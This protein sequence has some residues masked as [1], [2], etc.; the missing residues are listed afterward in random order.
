MIG[1]N[2]RIAAGLAALALLGAVPFLASFSLEFSGA[3]AVAVLY[4]FAVLSVVILTGYVG[5]FSLCQATFMGISAFGTAALVNHGWAYLPAAGV[6]VTLSFL[7]GVLVALPAL[8][9]SGILLAVV[10]AG[11]AL[12][13]D[14][15]FFQDNAFSWFNGGVSGWGISG[16]TIFGQQLDGLSPEHLRTLFLISLGIFAVVAVLVV[17][18][19]DSGSGRR[20][21][22]IRDSEV[23]AATMGV[24]LTRYKLL[25][26]GLSAAVA[27]IGGAI[28]P[29]VQGSVTQSPFNFFYSLQ[30]AAIAVLMGIRFIP[31]ATLGGIFIAFTPPLLPRLQD[32]ASNVLHQPIEI[33]G[34]WF[35]LVLGTLLVVQI[36]LYPDGVWGDAAHRVMALINPPQTRRGAK[37]VAA[38]RR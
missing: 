32:L 23:A 6:G 14:Y 38:A 13:F 26:F 27:G 35:Q 34:L 15:F 4:G 9:L 11:V 33:K 20:F 12:S 5:Q 21:R 10:T 19:H 2:G 3:A 36:I 24:D 18:I 30:V 37:P 8:R 22:A 7:L 16:Q 29:L 31:A 25:A 17:N 1:R 28:Y